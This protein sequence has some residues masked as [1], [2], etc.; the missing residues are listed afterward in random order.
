MRQNGF[1][2][3]PTH[4]LKSLDVVAFLYQRNDKQHRALSAVVEMVERGFRLEL[5]ERD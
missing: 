4:P 3:R 2:I 5:G 1:Q